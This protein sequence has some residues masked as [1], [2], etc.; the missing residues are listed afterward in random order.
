M[1]RGEQTAASSA[2][3]RPAERRR[4]GR[5]RAGVEPGAP[6]EGRQPP[7][8][9]G[10]QRQ[11]AGRVGRH[12]DELR[13][14]CRTGVRRSTPSAA[15]TRHRAAPDSP[16]SKLPTDTQTRDP[17]LRRSFVPGQ[18]ADRGDAARAARPRAGVAGA[19]ARRLGLPHRD[20]LGRRHPDQG[21]VHRRVGD[22]QRAEHPGPRRRHLAGAGPR[23]VRT[24]ERAVDRGLHADGQLVLRLPVRRDA[25][26]PWASP[27]RA[28]RRAWPRSTRSSSPIALALAPALLAGIGASGVD[29]AMVRVAALGHRRRSAVDGHQ[30]GVGHHPLRRGGAPTAQPHRR[31]RV[32]HPGPA[33][34]HGRGR[35]GHP[36]R[37]AGLHLHG[38]RLRA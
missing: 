33:G 22:D 35:T 3:G 6:L 28:T 23:P 5:H 25:C 30:G 31:H 16:T 8:H 18:D 1:A 37:R 29:G 34:L 9:P 19:P 14:G 17:A 27:P 7:H 36:G 4:D 38:R 20:R 12:R 13:S 11:R 2:H 21:G 15:P 26:S 10:A 24:R 32:P